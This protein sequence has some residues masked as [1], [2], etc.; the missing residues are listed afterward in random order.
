MGSLIGFR[1][2]REVTFTIDIQTLLSFEKIG[3]DY[4]K[5]TP[6]AR[7][8][9]PTDKSL[10]NNTTY[11]LQAEWTDHPA[12]LKKHKVILYIHGGAFV[13]GTAAIYR[14]L[15][16]KLTSSC[17]IPV[18]AV[19][20]RLAPENPFPAGIHDVLAAYL[21]LLEPHSAIFTQSNHPDYI[22]E[23][24]KPEDI[25]ILGDSA[26]GNLIQSFLNYLNH[27]LRSPD[28]KLLVPMPKGTV[29]ISPWVDLTCA[30]KSYAENKDFDIIPFKLSNLHEP[31]TDSFEHP[32]YS[33]CF[34][35]AITDKHTES[36]EFALMTPTVSYQE[37]NLKR[38]GSVLDTD[39]VER[40]TRHPLISPIFGD[41]AGLPPALIQAGDAEVLKDETLALA[42]KYSKAG[43]IVRHE[44]YRDMVHNF[45][46]A[47]VLAES[48]LAIKRI[49]IFIDEVFEDKMECGGEL[50]TD[51]E[52]RLCMLNVHEK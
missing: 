18:F 33:Y 17:N 28:G 46:V 16:E 9:I 44:L 8:P 11:T 20:Y 21:Y 31:I 27:Y 40:I 37:L 24:Y 45:Q 23:G 34:G 14:V 39:S 2:H 22:H 10:L 52:K 3:K 25:I 51:D 5:T 50:L 7:Y 32:V 43:S 4:V 29:L 13:F 49:R 42:F 15:S 48:L 35:T 19:N 30:S 38:I 12:A 36:E 26:G 41:M 6:N 47:P 1:N